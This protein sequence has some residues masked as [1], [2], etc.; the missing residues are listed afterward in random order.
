MGAE[1]LRAGVPQILIR[2]VK[3][4]MYFQV[5]K[6]RHFRQN[7]YRF[8]LFLCRKTHMLELDVQQTTTNTG[9]GEEYVQSMKNAYSL[10]L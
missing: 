3:W 9:Q 8:W 1:E 6:I 5:M 4:P 7:V 2:G 10:Y